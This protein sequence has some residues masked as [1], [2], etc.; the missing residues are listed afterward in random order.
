MKIQLMQTTPRVG[1]ISGN[2][3][4][5]MQA[6]GQASSDIDLMVFSELMLTGYPPEDLLLRPAFMEAVGVAAQ[7]IIQC[8]GQSI[9]VFGMP[10]WWGDALYNS[11]CVAQDGKLIGYYDKQKLPNYGV[12]DEQRY[13]TSGDGKQVVFEACGWKIGLGI[14]ED[15]W[16]DKLAQAQE[17]FACDVWLNLNA[18]PFHTNKQHERET[19]TKRRAKQFSCPLVYV[20]PVGG[21]DE[22]VF[23]GGSHVVAAEG[24]MLMR[25]PLF[26]DTEATINLAD[27]GQY[28]L[29]D[30]PE[31]IAQIYKALVLGTKDYVQRNGSTQV[32]LGL[33]GGIDSALTAAIA[34]DALGKANVLAVLL[35]S[36]CSSDHSIKD[37]QDLVKNLG[38]ESIT[39]PIAKS[40][41]AIEHTLADTFQAWGKAEADVTEENIQARARGVLL[42]AI[43]NKTGRMLLTTGNKSEMAV[44]Y[45][46]LYGDMAGGFAVLKDVYKM[47]VFALCDYL[48]RDIEVIPQNTIDKPPSAELRPDQ[49]DSDSLPEY[50]VL[51]AILKAS[52][53][54]RLSVTEIAA[55]GYDK[56]EVARIVGLLMLAEYK[57]RQSPLGV[58]I[59]Q[60]AF[61]RDRRYPITHAFRDVS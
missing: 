6:I 33:S 59:T 37:A 34:V 61:G 32:V 52:I 5:I 20:N 55:L 47:E 14:C 44:G 11:A 18:S 60:R 26:Q 27:V 31:P 25:L 30:V 21:Q 4:I 40:V 56:E 49:K 3:E 8:S 22:V 53:E 43:S 15:L 2:A 45:A 39:L 23:D 29:A 7:A 13:F 38:I 58:K 57:R 46:T 36:S 12:F 50:A 17:K 16:S 41:S 54:A 28:Q 42:M 10:R 48:N 51:D 24:D 19:L 1:D 35:P 9:V